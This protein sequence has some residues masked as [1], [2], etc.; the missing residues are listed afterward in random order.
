MLQTAGT[1]SAA[2]V[3]HC[4]EPSERN[5]AIFLD[6]IATFP[7][8]ARIQPVKL[9]MSDEPGELDLIVSGRGG[10]NSIY[11]RSTTPE[12]FTSERI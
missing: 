9:G 8:S 3:V 1:D 4:F 7:D 11:H 5:H 2:F 10:A 6:K 12:D